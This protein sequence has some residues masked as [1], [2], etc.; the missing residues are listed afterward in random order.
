MKILILVE[1]YPR[2]CGGISLMYIHTRNLYYQKHGIEVEVLNFRAD[3]N[4]IYE[5]I[6]VITLEHY[7]QYRPNY[8]LLI[9]HAANLKHH[10]LFLKKYGKGFE[11]FLF[12]YHGHEVL[13]I[14]QVYSK[15]Y[16]YI[17]RN[18]VK[19][20]LQDLYDDFKLYI[21]RRYL[22]KIRFKSEFVFVSQWMKD[23]FF[24]WTRI[25]ER[26]MNERCHITY[27]CVGELFENLAYDDKRQKEYDFI[28]IRGN[29]DGSKYA[30]D[31]VN[32]LAKNTPDR[33]FLLIGKGQFFDHYEKASNITWKDQTMHH[34]EI[35]EALNEARF[36]LMPTRTDAQGLMMCEMAAYGIPL[37]TS[38]LPVCHEIFDGFANVSFIKNENENLSLEELARRESVCM[39]DHRYD[40]AITIC[41][42]IE[43]ITHR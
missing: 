35:I 42:E 18:R 2:Q 9:I 3:Q 26:Q 16:P 15:P 14:N 30:I 41:R 29:L 5:N 10:Y 28:T 33:K 1:D 13:K 25:D 22:P 7:K 43:M 36:A 34:T 40:Q 12:F 31:L 19:E 17:Q 32:Q 6:P 4:Y 38:D 8:D 20:K 11:R 37:I 23:E 39:K 27:N 21:W 24:K